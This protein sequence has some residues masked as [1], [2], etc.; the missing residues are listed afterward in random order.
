MYLILRGVLL[1]LNLGQSQLKV[2]YV[3]LQ[4]RTFVL[5]FP[6]LGRQ[7]S[8]HLF[9][10]LSSL[11]HFLDLSLQLELGFNQLITSFLCIQQVFTFL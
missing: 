5:Q 7:L 9:L 3:F 6:L 11:C 8:I 4:F 10:I 1:L 2:I